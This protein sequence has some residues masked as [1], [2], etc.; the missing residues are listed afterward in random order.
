MTKVSRNLKFGLKAQVILN[1]LDRKELTSQGDLSPV[2]VPVKVS[3]NLTSAFMCSQK[4]R[5]P[6][7]LSDYLMDR[8]GHILG[9]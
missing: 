1:Q 3:N 8:L 2:D 9:E 6:S 7:D 4:K 5:N